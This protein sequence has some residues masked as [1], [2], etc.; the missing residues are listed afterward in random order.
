MGEEFGKVMTWPFGDLLFPEDDTS[1]GDGGTPVVTAADTGNVSVPSVEAQAAQ[2]RLARLSK[3]FT[4][5]TGA[6]GA[7][8]IGSQGVFS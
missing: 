5:P 2:R 7:L 4:S 6:L 3:Y 1:G 8:N